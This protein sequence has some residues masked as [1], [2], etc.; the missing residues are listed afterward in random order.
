MKTAQPK[1]IDKNRRL[2]RLLSV[3]KWLVAIIVAVVVLPIAA[4]A[5]LQVISSQSALGGYLQRWGES[6][7]FD[8]SADLVGGGKEHYDSFVATLSGTKNFTD[9]KN[10]KLDMSFTGFGDGGLFNGEVRYVTDAAYL[11]VEKFGVLRYLLSFSTAEPQS[12]FKYKIDNSGKNRTQC[13]NGNGNGSESWMTFMSKVPLTNVAFKGV[14]VMNNDLS[15]HYAGSVDMSKLKQAVVDFNKKLPTDCQ[16]SPTSIRYQ[17]LAVSYELWRGWSSDRMVITFI[18]YD[19]KVKDVITLDTSGYN[20]PPVTI[21]AP[22]SASDLSTF[23]K[24][25]LDLKNFDTDDGPGSID[26]END[27]GYNGWSDLGK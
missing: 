25:G 9:P 1:P 11:K 4:I 13:L 10:P 26:Q 24:P 23:I 6:K 19:F 2:K 8:F 7:T 22:S 20:K 15:L 16:I 5:Y 3:N 21:N 27:S 18:N 12:W 14:E 17:D